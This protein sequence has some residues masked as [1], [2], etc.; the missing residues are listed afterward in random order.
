VALFAPKQRCL[1]EIDRL[2]GEGADSVNSAALRSH[3]AGGPRPAGVRYDQT[4]RG[5]GYGLRAR[6]LSQ[7]NCWSL[8]PSNS[9]GTALS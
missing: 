6:H 7:L 9:A 8:A 3:R 4:A 1:D 2:R 5:S